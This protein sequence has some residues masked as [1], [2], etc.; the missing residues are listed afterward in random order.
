MPSATTTTTEEAVTTLSTSEADNSTPF[1]VTRVAI[2]EGLASVI[3]E[4]VG[5]VRVGALSL[6][7]AK[8]PAIEVSL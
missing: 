1:E 4:A 6:E 7:E 8:L 2:G 5:T 3:V